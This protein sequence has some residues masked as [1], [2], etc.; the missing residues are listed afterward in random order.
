[1]IEVF[2]GKDASQA[3]LKAF[4]IDEETLRKKKL[5]REKGLLKDPGPSP[6][7]KSDTIPLEGFNKE[8]DEWKAR[9][10]LY[11]AQ[12][13]A[14]KEAEGYNVFGS[15]KSGLK[16]MKKKLGDGATAISKGAGDLAKDLKEK[17]TKKGGWKDKIGKK[18]SDMGTSI[19]TGAE[20]LKTTI[21][22]K[23]GP[24]LTKMSDGFKSLGGMLKK[25]A[26]MLWGAIV[27]FATVTIP[28][29]VGAF[30]GMTI[31]I[32]GVTLPLWAIVLAV[33]AI[34]VGIWYFWDEIKAGWEKTKQWFSDAV[35]TVK[36]WGPKIK[37]WFT[38]LGEDI[39]YNIQWLIAKIK[40]GILSMAN[41]VI[42]KINWLPGVDI[43]KFDIDNVEGVETRR[44]EQLAARNPADAQQD[45]FN[46]EDDKWSMSKFPFG[47]KSNFSNQTQINNNTTSRTH[48]TGTA[49]P[50]DSFLRTQNEVR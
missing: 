14:I 40:D 34:A 32:A 37:T 12:Q 21:K 50:R 11:D 31:A 10:D 4:G 1:M 46:A 29:L 30:M 16:S 6:L 35:D 23:F 33:I 45:L 49:Q 3:F 19:S 38:E 47:N 20:N 28:A 17:W 8:Y 42:D 41:W 39:A 2:A 5:E 27:T 36:S 13:K 48:Y 15:I 26:G 22:E 7:K 44:A 43:E 24:H 9:K 25:G 18:F